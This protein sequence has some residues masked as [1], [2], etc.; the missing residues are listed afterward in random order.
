MRLA[1]YKNLIDEVLKLPTDI[2]NTYLGFAYNPREATVFAVMKQARLD[3]DALFDGE[4]V[5]LH[6]YIRD[7]L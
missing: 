7:K 1:A 2:N 4:F 3:V 5:E 6:E